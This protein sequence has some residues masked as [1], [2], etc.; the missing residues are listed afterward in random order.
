MSVCRGGT[1]SQAVFKLGW[2]VSNAPIQDTFYIPL[3]E[4]SF[5][6][7]QETLT[8]EMTRALTRIAA[9]DGMDEIV[10]SKYG[11]RIELANEIFSLNDVVPRVVNYLRMTGPG[12]YR[13]I[14]VTGLEDFVDR[15]ESTEATPELPAT[16][17]RKRRSFR[18]PW[19]PATV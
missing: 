14:V 1:P 4:S 12:S 5:L 18:W 17:S 15:D 2:K 19:Q 3:R 13:E 11:V 16:V 6:V 8:P 10:V 7:A 9:L